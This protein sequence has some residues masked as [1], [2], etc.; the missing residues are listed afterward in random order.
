VVCRPD[1]VVEGIKQLSRLQHGVKNHPDLHNP[2]TF[3]VDYPA[4]GRF[5]VHVGKV[6][7]YGGAGLQIFLD[8]ELKLEKLFPDED[9]HQREIT[10]FNGDY[11]IDVPAGSHAI[12]VENPGADWV[13]LDYLLP[14]Y[15]RKSNPPVRLYALAAPGALATEPTVLL[16]ARHEAFNW[17]R[18]SLG[19]KEW[20][21]PPTEVVLTGIPAG[22]Y[23]V[24]L[25]NTLTGKI[26]PGGMF[27]TV[28]GTL[29]ITLPAFNKSLATRLFL[30]SP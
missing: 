30:V 14:D 6:S 20:P 29:R 17:Y 23:R 3:E 24:E 12:L 10:T 21:V 4:D 2:V 11:E 28:S 26:H 1:G 19:L 15:T 27:T 8:G 16:W 7:G 5:V 25:W 13:F 22:R 9:D 18:H